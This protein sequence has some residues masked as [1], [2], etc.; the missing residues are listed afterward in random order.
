M[1]KTNVCRAIEL[2]H[3]VHIYQQKAYNKRLVL[4]KNQVCAFDEQYEFVVYTLGL[5]SNHDKSCPEKIIF[6][7]HYK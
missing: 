4:A 2:I 5:T 6:L 7:L 1:K 3:H